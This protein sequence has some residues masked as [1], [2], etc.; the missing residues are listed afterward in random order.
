[1]NE[2]ASSRSSNYKLFKTDFVKSTYFGLDSEYFSKRF[3]AY[4]T[5]N[6][7]LPVEVGRWSG[8]PIHE[9]RCN[10]CASD[11]GD[12]YHYLLICTYFLSQRKQCIKPFY[13]TRPNVLKY[14]DL[15]NCNNKVQLTNLCRFVDII[16]KSDLM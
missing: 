12:E 9:R 15:M 13:Y 10:R 11:I 16:L 2:A 7:R 8:I 4:R 1:M 3:L 5:R 14:K 6:H